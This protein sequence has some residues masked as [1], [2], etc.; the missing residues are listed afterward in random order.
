HP[1][2]ARHWGSA[3]CSS[4]LRAHRGAEGAREVGLVGEAGVEGDGGEGGVGGGEGG[5][6]GAHAEPPEV[7][8]D[9]AAEVPAEGPGE[10]DAVDARL[11]REGRCGRRSDGLVVEAV[12]D[13]AEP[14]RWRTRGGWGVLG[15]GEEEGEGVV[16]R[17]SRTRSGVGRG[18]AA[19]AEGAAGGG[20]AVAPAPARGGVLHP[21]EEAGGEL[22]GEHP[23]A[24]RPEPVP[25][26]GPRR[27][28]DDRER[29]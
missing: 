22:E 19:E 29:P 1:S 7:G 17:L 28:D 12:A 9:R 5:G 6:G 18:G 8:R 4:A 25:V 20:V 14:A 26:H 21:V 2:F 13:V 10:R 3:V 16:E 11:V 27:P 24:L 23:R 15:R